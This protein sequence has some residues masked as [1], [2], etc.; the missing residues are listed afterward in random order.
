LVPSGKIGYMKDD[1]GRPLHDLKWGPRYL[2]SI[3]VQWQDGKQTGVWPVMSHEHFNQG[4][5]DMLCYFLGHST[6]NYSEKKAFRDIYAR[7]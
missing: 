4:S 1:Q 3:G 7:N 5:G 2:T 6:R